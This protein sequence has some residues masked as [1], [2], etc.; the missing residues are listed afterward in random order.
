MNFFA[1]QNLVNNNSGLLASVADL[2][3]MSPNYITDD[4]TTAHYVG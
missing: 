1:K 4:L 3:L 2:D